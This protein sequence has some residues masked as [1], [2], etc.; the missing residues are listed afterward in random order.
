MKVSR[1]AMAAIVPATI[2]C[3]STALLAQSAE[4]REESQAMVL[5]RGLPTLDTRHSIAIVELDP[6]SENFGKL[7]SEVEQPDMVHPFHHMYYSPNGRLYTTGL[8]PTCSLAEIG[9]AR[10]ATGTP[11]VT[12]F[13][14]LDTAGQM[15]GPMASQNLSVTL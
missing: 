9:L 5:L 13:D 10:D 3:L 14:C 6:E 4:A 8:D 11:M 15:V 1:I 7:L 12:G 2:A